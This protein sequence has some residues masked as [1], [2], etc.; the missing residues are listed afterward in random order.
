MFCGE[1]PGASAT[2]R[3]CFTKTQQK[4]LNKHKIQGPPDSGIKNGSWVGPS[5]LLLF[6]SYC[7]K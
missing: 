1:S 4:K 5:F 3:R 7:T 6:L 2:I